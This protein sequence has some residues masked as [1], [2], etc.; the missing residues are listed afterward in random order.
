MFKDEQVYKGQEVD[1]LLFVLQQGIE[2]GKRPVG[3][4]RLFIAARLRSFI[5]FLIQILRVLIVVA[6]DAEQLPIAAV[7]GVVVVVVILVMDGELTKPLARK[8]AAAPSTDPW[9]HL[10]R[11]LPIGLL[12][13]LSLMPGL[14]DDLVEPVF[15]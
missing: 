4:R 14:G 13:K 2:V 11:P 10:E 6:V 5:P 1:Q 7:R 8:F 9:E 12:L 15:V 3:S